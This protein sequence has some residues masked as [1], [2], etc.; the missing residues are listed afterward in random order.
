MSSETKTSRPPQT[1][2]LTTIAAKRLG[3]EFMEFKKSNHKTMFLEMVDNSLAHF[4]AMVLGPEG[5]PYEGGFFLFDIK[6]TSDY[7]NQPPMVI[8]ITPLRNDCRLHPNLY[9]NDENRQ[10]GKVCLSIL[11]TW[12]KYEWSPALTIEKI[13]VTISGLLDNNPIANE[14]GMEKSPKATQEM[15]SMGSRYWT[16]YTAQEV[17]SRKDI[18]ESFIREARRFMVEHIE[19]Y[20]K[21][22]QILKDFKTDYIH[23]MHAN[24]ALVLKTVDEWIA[25]FTD[26]KKRRDLLKAKSSEK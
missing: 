10:G 8:H 17:I 11:G 12:G 18:P 2:S 15:Y 25:K 20:I 14:P 9:A 3:K 24:I 22:A 16:L 6:P 7:P 23:S 21:S 13:L 1:G 19:V 4:Q 5:T 26:Q